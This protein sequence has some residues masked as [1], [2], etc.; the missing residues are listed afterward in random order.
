[1]LI[2]VLEQLING[3]FS[4]IPRPRPHFTTVKQVH[5]IA[6]RGAH[7]N[8]QGIFENTDDAFRLAKDLGYWGIELDVHATADNQ[9]VVNHDPTLKR[10]WGQDLAIAQLNFNQLR[11][12]APK[13]PSLQEVVANY[14]GKMHLFIEIK[15]PIKDQ[16]DLIAILND[17]KPCQDYHLLSLHAVD[18]SVLTQFPK[19]ALLLVPMHNNVKQF[20]AL[21]LKENYGGVLGHYLFLR[22]SQI[23]QLKRAKQMT[24]VGFVDSKYS[25]YRELNRGINWLFTNKAEE[26]SQHLQDL[27]QDAFV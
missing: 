2:S 14:G 25:M 19:E 9:L 1:M 13:V 23:R 12:L 26:V 11:E 4:C 6:H 5:L 21:S 27:R 18:L 16:R 22:N 24:G 17:L 10:L 7:K 3:Y 8:A 15:Y 20:C